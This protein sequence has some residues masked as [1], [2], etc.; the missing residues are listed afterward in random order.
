MGTSAPFLLAPF[1]GLAGLLSPQVW[2]IEMA[3]A[4]RTQELPQL[5][6]TKGHGEDVGILPIRRN[7]R[8][9]NFT[10]ED[11]LADKVVVHLNVLSPGVEDGVLC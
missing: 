5:V 1:R 11:T 7:I 9:F 3:Q 10:R 2:Y 8:K 4:K 6:K